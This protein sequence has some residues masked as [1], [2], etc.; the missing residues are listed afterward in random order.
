[1]SIG[2]VAG[3]SG[4]WLVSLGMGCSVEV[5]GFSVGSVAGQLGVCLFSCG[6]GWSFGGLS[7]QL[8]VWLVSGQVGAW[9]V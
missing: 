9:A 7:F 5:C 6:R 8:R 4:V 3:P 1:M 2:S